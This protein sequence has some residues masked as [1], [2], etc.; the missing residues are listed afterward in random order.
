MADQRQMQIGEVAERTGLSLRTIRHYEEVSLVIPSARSKGG[1]RLYTESDVERLMV[2][3]RMKPLD[4]SLEEMRDLLDIT[5]RLAASDDPPVGEE[6]ERL[7]ER[8][9]SYREVADA[10]CETLRAR[11]EMA[12]DFASTLRNRL[13]ADTRAGA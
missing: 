5:D 11:L 9:D 10:R 4:F 12:E 1:F 8:L 13:Q 7:R 3:R 2:I 6:R